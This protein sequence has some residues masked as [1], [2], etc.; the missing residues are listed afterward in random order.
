VYF[1]LEENEMTSEEYK[2][3]KVFVGVNNPDIWCQLVGISRDTDKSISCGR[4]D[5]SEKVESAIASML[6]SKPVAVAMLADKLRIIFHEARFD[7]ALDELTNDI[8]VSATDG[9]IKIVVKNCGRDFMGQHFY[10]FDGMN[11]RRNTL[12]LYPKTGPVQGKAYS[13]DEC[14]WCWWRVEGPADSNVGMIAYQSYR[15]PLAKST[16][17]KNFPIKL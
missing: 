10:T 9:S 14:D 2:A 13:M 5:I 8:A 16:F 7:V 17:E 6:R 15:N 1:R 4:L 3:A 12:L 11:S